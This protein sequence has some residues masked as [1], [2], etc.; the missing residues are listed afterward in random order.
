MR[1]RALHVAATAAV[2]TTFAMAAMAQSGPRPVDKDARDLLDKDP[3]SV[4][5]RRAMVNRVYSQTRSRATLESGKLGGPE[6][7]IYGDDHRVDP[8]AETDPNLV[9]LTD[10]I[11]VVVS[12]FELTD[13]GDGTYTLST[14]PWTFQSGSSIC[15]DEPFRGQETIGFCSGFFLGGDLV[16]TAGHCIDASDVGSTAF[17]FAYKQISETEAP[18][19]VIPADRVYFTTAIVDRALGGGDDHT[20]VQVDRAV[21]GR[22]P[23]PLSRDGAPPVG[24]PLVVIGHPAALPMKIAGGAEVKSIQSGYLQSN[25]D[26]YGGNSGSAV[27]NANT[28]EIEGIL[29]R[30]APDYTSG[31]GGCTQSNRVADTGNTGGGLAFEEGSLAETF[32]G[33]VPE[34]GLTVSPA[35]GAYHIGPVGG[36]FDP[37]SVIYTLRNPTNDP[38]SYDIQLSG[39]GLLE[40]NPSRVSGTLPAQGEEPL[41]VALAGSVSGLPAGV[42]SETLTISDLTNNETLERTH[43]V[44]IGQSVVSVTPG[45]DFQSSGPIGG[46][47]PG[48]LDYTITNDRPV[49]TTI[50][51]ASDASWLL[52][53][54]GA[55]DML[56]LPANGDSGMV[57]LSVG[58]SAD[59]LAPGI[60]TATVTFTNTVSGEVET[61][62]ASL[63]VGRLSYASTDTPISIPDNGA[64]QS[65][66]EVPGGFCSAD[67]DVVLDISHTF[68]GDLIVD[69]MSPDGT[70]VRLHNR[71]GGG[72]NDLMET[73]DDDGD[74]INPD[75]P[76]TLADFVGS[77]ASGDWTLTISDN[78]GSD[79][80][81]LNSWSLRIGVSGDG[82]PPQAFDV[83]AAGPIHLPVDL[84]LD[85]QSL[86]SLPLDYV[87]TSLPANGILWH[88]GQAVMAAPYTIPAVKSGPALVYRPNLGFSG[89]DGFT[90]YAE[91]MAVSAE[92]DVTVNIGQAGVLYDFPMNTD[93]NWQTEGDWAFGIPR[94]ISGD[95]SSGATGDNVYGYN[96]DGD[97][98]NN[99]SPARYLTSEVMDLSGQTGAVLT[100]QRHLGVER[101]VYD[102][103]TVELS[104]DDGATWQNL[105]TN[106]SGSSLDDSA[107]TEMSF[108]I[109][110]QADGASAVRVRWG[111]GTT[112][113]SV[114]FHGWNIDD[115]QILVDADAPASDM[116][117]DGTANGQ[118]DGQ[119]TLSDFSYYLALW[120]AGAPQADLTTNG[121]SNGL[122]DGAVS[123]SDFS[124]YLSL[125]SGQQ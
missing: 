86:E 101:S 71:S 62:D 124:Y 20:V 43:E 40:L 69:L 46:P 100:F 10:S 65:V 108:D 48:S 19:M 52:V 21:T 56:S 97:Y 60:Y 122:G 120:S 119:V 96:L 113:S 30:G 45:L 111:M 88:N 42:Y 104:A 17:V 36:P 16:G 114:T 53:N 22:S 107:W 61:R 27:F 13:N 38:I 77:A 3:T 125:W 89:S 12:T 41:V 24:T 1:A 49:A 116:T 47:F 84:S 117:T 25:L 76:G 95:P 110:A 80:G 78:A 7:V 99:L 15:A 106:P 115:V 109:S 55:N 112:D 32:A 123:L 92:A 79:V 4:Q 63:D 9:A 91:D 67:V 44:E 35:A 6:P 39:E 87:I 64:I 66:I 93:P 90:Y 8:Y 26:T 5:A 70:T 54:G 81:T 72:T 37:F 14:D 68:K 94:G 102:D 82:C 118:P 59:G 73:Y 33:F 75:G 18:E 34:V 83:A 105:W 74:G 121:T 98:P 29:V 58:S 50:N 28:L 85:A 51:V 2:C 31:P 11:C 57:S 23:L 103:A